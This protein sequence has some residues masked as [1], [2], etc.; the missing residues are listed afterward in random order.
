M[1]HIGQKGYQ[2]QKSRVRQDPW[3]DSRFRRRRRYATQSRVPHTTLVIHFLECET[4]D[5][6]NGRSQLR[7]AEG[8][9]RNVLKSA[10]ALRYH[11]ASCRTRLAARRG[12]ADLA[13]R[14]A[15]LIGSL[16]IMTG[17]LY[18]FHREIAKVD[19]FGAGNA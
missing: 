12:D 14:D 18:L 6:K 19:R 3:S 16:G 13:S 17:T 7:A 15:I 11:G 4:C 9:G 2:S 8:L 5:Q 10:R 1:L